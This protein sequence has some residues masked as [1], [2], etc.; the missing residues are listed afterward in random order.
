MC[1]VC[2]LILLRF[3]CLFLSDNERR[4]F[5]ELCPPN[6]DIIYSQSNQD[7]AHDGDPSYQTR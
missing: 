3:H 6:A 1:G 4:G 5:V 2:A 7:P